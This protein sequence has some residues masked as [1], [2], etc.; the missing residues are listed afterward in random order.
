MTLQII[1]LVA[2]RLLAVIIV[3]NLKI[4]P[5]VHSEMSG[6]NEVNQQDLM[7]FQTSHQAWEI[8]LISTSAVKALV[9]LI[10]SLDHIER[11]VLKYG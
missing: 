11:K 7:N 9:I 1:H 10:C 6:N 3:R 8:L 2:S 5:S 4:L